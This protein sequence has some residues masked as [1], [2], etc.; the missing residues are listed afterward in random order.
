MAVAH[1]LAAAGPLLVLQT[2]PLTLLMLPFLLWHWLFVRRRYLLLIDHWS[3]RKLSWQQ[4]EWRVVLEDGRELEV[5]PESGS[6]LAGVVTLLQLRVSGN[7]RRLRV[8][9]FRD[10]SDSDSLRRLRVRL[11]FYRDTE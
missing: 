6:V 7:G 9:L 5:K 4:D 11:R 8:P 2:H 3:V 1:L 10:S